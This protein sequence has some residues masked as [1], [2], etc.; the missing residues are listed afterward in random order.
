MPISLRHM[1][2]QAVWR[3]SSGAEFRDIIHFHEGIEIFYIEQGEGQIVIGSKKFE[4]SDGTLLFFQPFQLHKLAI[5][6]SDAKPF[7]RSFIVY[8]P[9]W[10]QACL[11]PFPQLA[12]FHRRLWKKAWSSQAVQTAGPDDP[13]ALHM[14]ELAALALP[15]PQHDR[16]GTEASAL[17]LLRLLTLLAGGALRSDRADA[18]REGSH[19]ER[20]MEW[21]DRRFREPFRLRELADELHLTPAYVSGLFRKE[22]GENLTD[23]LAARRM[24]EACRLLETTELAVERVAEAVG[25][26]SA[27]HFCRLFKQ[28]LGESP[29]RFRLRL[30]S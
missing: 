2:A 22:V 5:S 8:E 17:F 16:S 11:Q 24:Q 1:P 23:Y 7:V 28:R 15:R 14:R 4:V 19:A 20:A 27:S 25:I 30:R 6:A 29:R 3:R 9:S 26:P 13:L 12:D 21:L 18:P 10:L